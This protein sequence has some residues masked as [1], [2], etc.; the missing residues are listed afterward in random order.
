M[1]FT[2]GGYYNGLQLLSIAGV[3]TE[4]YNIALSL[5]STKSGF[6][7]PNHESINVPPFNQL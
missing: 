1:V 4:V 6:H 2:F 5:L 3:I 7:L